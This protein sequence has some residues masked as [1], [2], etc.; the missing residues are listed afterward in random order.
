MIILEIGSHKWFQKIESMFSVFIVVQ[1]IMEK[2]F[3]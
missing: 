3:F 1:I 2:I